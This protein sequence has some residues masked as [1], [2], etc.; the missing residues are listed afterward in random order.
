M[1]G[2]QAQLFSKIA[3]VTLRRF[4]KAGKLIPVKL[5]LSGKRIFALSNHVETILTAAVLQ[6]GVLAITLNPPHNSQSFSQAW[7]TTMV[8]TEALANLLTGIAIP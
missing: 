2:C 3:H 4:R 6:R 7:A 5:H 8:I 1:A